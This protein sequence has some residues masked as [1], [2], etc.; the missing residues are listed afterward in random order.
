MNRVKLI[1]ICGQLYWKQFIFIFIQECGRKYVFL[2]LVFYLRN[3][4]FSHFSFEHLFL[5]EFSCDSFS[6][7]ME[8]D[9]DCDLDLIAIKL[10][11]FEMFYDLNRFPHVNFSSIE[12][13]MHPILTRNIWILIFPLKSKR[14]RGFYNPHNLNDIRK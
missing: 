11:T 10:R 8:M 6:M 12:S 7:E 1:G 13:F 5:V 4:F 9:L 3:A 14:L 2:F